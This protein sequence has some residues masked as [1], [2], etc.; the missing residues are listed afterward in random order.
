M[1][2]GTLQEL[3]LLYTEVNKDFKNCKT[4]RPEL[5]DLKN[6]FKMTYCF[7]NNILFQKMQMLF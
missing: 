3:H 2:K 1:V 4:N 6:I 5:D 7:Q